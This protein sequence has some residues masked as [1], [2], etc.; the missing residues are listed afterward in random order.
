[1]FEHEYE[2]DDFWFDKKYRLNSRGVVRF[3]NVSVY[4]NLTPKPLYIK[5]D[6]SHIGKGILDANEH[7]EHL[8]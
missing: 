5:F 6:F 2:P 8:K 7:P 3:P 1:M 4:D